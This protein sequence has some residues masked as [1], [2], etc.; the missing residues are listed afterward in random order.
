MRE[1]AL[2]YGEKLERKFIKRLEN[3]NQ[4]SPN[5]IQKRKFELE[6]WVNVEKKQIQEV[7]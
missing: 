3:K 5:S 2:I 6:K 7:K 4:L 1:E